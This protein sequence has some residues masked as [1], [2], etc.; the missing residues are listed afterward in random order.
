MNA[1]AG[2]SIG[3]AVSTERKLAALTQQQLANAAHVSVSLVRAVEQGRAPA[4]PS[5]VAAVAR[6]LG[7]SVADLQGQPPVSRTPDDR[8]I[9][10][11][12]PGLRREIA[13]YQL[14]GD[15]RIRPR[16]LDEI[17]ADVASISRRRHAG[18]LTSIGEDLPSLLAELRTHLT[19]QP[20]DERAYGLLAICYAAAGQVSY[21]LG[22]ADLSSL[23][24]DRVEWAAAR[25]GDELAV[26]A[27]DFY[28]AGELI[29]TAD[30]D[31][32]LRFLDGARERIAHRLDDEVGRAMS[33]QLH[34]K[35]GLAAA[36]QG[37]TDT[38]DAHVA[39]AERLAATVAANRND[40]DLAF[41]R[42]NVAVW[43][44]G[45]AVEAMDGGKALDRART[46][47]LPTW[48][49]SERAG[50]HWIDLARGRLLAG[51]KTGAF[52]ALATARSISPQQTKYHPQVHETARML[53]ASERRR[54]DSLANLVS[55]L[56]VDL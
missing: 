6:A 53:A 43:S 17:A 23:T 44:V 22:Y 24:T 37:D 50:H 40:Y 15:E 41:N 16:D 14:P 46:V 20:D 21:K 52:A 36:R 48:F 9:K 27:A 3:S 12:I 33:G 30:W 56:G 5:F 18:D 55:W 39:E 54:S 42:H 31:T 19:V 7:L 34:L 2:V 4:S 13:A 32:A 51:D 49:P 25:S 10:G 29:A 1:E 38:T 35:S 45:L 28:R 26:A 47:Q 8:R 11:V